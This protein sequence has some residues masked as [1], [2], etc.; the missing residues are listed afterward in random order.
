MEEI[1]K[2]LIGRKTVTF[3]CDE[4][5][6]EGI[7]SKTEYERN[8]RL[9]RKNYCCRSCAAKGAN[10]TKATKKYECSDALKEHLKSIAGNRGDEYT[11]FRYTLRCIKRRFKEIDIDLPYLK[12]V[13]ENQKGICPYTGLNLIPP[14]DTNVNTL[15]ITLRSSL[16]RI[17]SSKGYIKGNI[18]FISTPI[19]YMK[20]TMTDLE[21]KKFL[22]L[23]SSY[24]SSF[25][26]D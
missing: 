24:T 18:Q 21:T 23:I 26:E 15:D 3:I 9:G 17:D 14:T 25:E 11:P 2:S 5:G 20:S 19:N 10:R 7:K 4:C 12:E 8:L 16:D 6:K 13:W 1:K 22:K